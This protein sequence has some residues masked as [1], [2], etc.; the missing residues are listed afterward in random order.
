MSG[1][2]LH[3]PPTFSLRHGL[4]LTQMRSWLTGLLW[5]ASSIWGTISAFPRLN[6]KKASM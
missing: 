3:H 2:I 1:I 5:L 4:S 6:D